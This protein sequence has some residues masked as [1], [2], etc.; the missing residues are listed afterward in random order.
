[1]PNKKIAVLGAGSGGFA[2]A[3]DLTQRG[4]TVNLFEHPRF[5]ENIQGAKDK[6]GINASGVVPQEFVKLNNITTDIEEA[7]DG[8]D[9]ILLV[10]P[11]YGVEAFAEHCIPHLK[12]GQMVVLTMAATAGALRFRQKV[13]EITPNLKIK[14]GETASLPYGCRRTGPTEVT[15]LIQVENLFLSA[16]PATDTPELIAEFQNLYPAIISAENTLETTLNN[17]N[18]ITHPSASILNAGRIEFAKGEYYLYP[19]GI[20]PGVA[21][22]IEAVDRERLALCR[23]LGFREISSKERIAKYGYAKPRETLYEEYHASEVFDKAKGPSG[24][25]DRYLT[26][27]IPFGLVLWASLGKSLGIKT[28]TMD[29]VIDIGSILCQR[30]FRSEGLTAEKLGLD[31]LSATQLN[32]YLRTGKK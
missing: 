16:F 17:G 18:P 4:F 8:T 11:A 15:I 1:M 32:A 20:S 31:G 13:K 2:A 7:L 21:R 26:E 22:V 27:D 19:E 28:N 3:V 5:S 24:L 12:D 9:I 6:G 14:V 29:A 30:D 23:A 10:V 25:Q